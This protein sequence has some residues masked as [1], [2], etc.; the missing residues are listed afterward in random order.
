MEKIIYSRNRGRGIIL[1][2]DDDDNELFIRLPISINDIYIYPD[3]FTT[4]SDFFPKPLQYIGLLAEDQKCMVFLLTK[5][6]NLFEE[7]RYYSCW[8]RIAEDKLF[9][10]FSEIG[11]RDFNY[12]NGQ[13]K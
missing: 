6:S 1:G 11:G 13:W 8:W 9:N 5:Q 10:M 12:I 2:E 7:L 3:D 4:M